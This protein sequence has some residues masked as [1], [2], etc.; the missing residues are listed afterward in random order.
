MYAEAKENLRGN[1]FDKAILM[2]DKLEGRAAGTPLAQQA[3]LDKAY[4]QYKSGDRVSAINTLERFIKLNPASPAMDYA[5]YLKG[6]INFN[7][8]LG[9]MSKWFKQDLAERDQL[10]ARES[11][12]AYKELVT[13]FPSP[14]TLKTP[15]CA[16][17][18][19]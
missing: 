11:F 7:D 16:C 4:A 8:D 6:T 19:S 1:L 15:P 9:L 18:T 5:M 17:A 13:R 3:Q 12:E 10:A 14:N 2:L